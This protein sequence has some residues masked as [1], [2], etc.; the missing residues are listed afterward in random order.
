MSSGY[1]SFPF[2]V[3][4]FP[5]NIYKSCREVKNG[6]KKKRPA[7]KTRLA[8]ASVFP[9]LFSGLGL[10]GGQYIVSNKKEVI[11]VGAHRRSHT[12]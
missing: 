12:N 2:P 6:R 7:P 5:H 4:R 11:E 10:P 8:R 1:M 9:G 3:S